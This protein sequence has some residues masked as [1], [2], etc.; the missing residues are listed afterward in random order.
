M[1]CSTNTAT[2]APSVADQCDQMVAS[3]GANVC[4]VRSKGRP[5]LLTVEHDTVVGVTDRRQGALEGTKFE[6]EERG[7]RGRR[8]R[9]FQWQQ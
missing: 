9:C 8:T 6:E 4:E 3:S 5:H 1:E 2:L 7:R